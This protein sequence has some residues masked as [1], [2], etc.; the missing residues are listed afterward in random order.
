MTRSKSL[1]ALTAIA[2]AVGLLG[3][4]AQ[5]AEGK[6]GGEKVRLRLHLEKGKSYALKT[7][8][9]QKIV[10]TIQGNKVE[11]DQT[12]GIEYTFDV[13][14]VKDDGTMAVKVTYRA[15]QMKMSGPVSKVDYDSAKATGEVPK[16]AR[17][18]AAL[19]GQSFT[20]DLTPEGR[21]TQVGGLDVMLAG[22][23]EKLALPE[24]AT[25]T[26]IEDQFKKHFGDKAMRETMERL[27]AV[28]PA[29]PVGIG[30]SWTKN[31][32]LTKRFPLEIETTYVL[33]GRKEGVATV[34]TR[35]TLKSDPKAEPMKMGP[36]SISYHLTGKQEGQME[37]DEATGWTVG[38]KLTQQF[39]GTMKMAGAPGM[40][41]PMSWPMTATS[42]ITLASPKA[43]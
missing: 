21:V 36:L 38:G 28:Y 22:M 19:V 41:E 29:R 4:V 20:L 39:S 12:T 42:T 26:M 9:Q 5:A 33:K 35:S 37:M 14:D 2:L 30:D 34:D 15:V 24:G 32:K 23:I 11:V 7:I 31:T 10:Q 1:L 25:K 8:V 43:K 3:A 16:L 6:A 40:S 17:G 18:L 13:R 27:M